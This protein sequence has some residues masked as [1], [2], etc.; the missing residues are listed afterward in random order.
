MIDKNKQKK[1]YLEKEK[2]EERLHTFMWDAVVMGKSLMPD[3]TIKDCKK[4]NMSN[5]KCDKLIEIT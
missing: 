2:K 1:I 4:E 3:G 5:Y